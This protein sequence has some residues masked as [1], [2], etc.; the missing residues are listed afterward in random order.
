VRGRLSVLSRRDLGMLATPL[1]VIAAGIGG[2]ALGHR[3][4]PNVADAA[5]ARKQAQSAS[6]RASQLLAYRRARALAEPRGR[7]Q[8]TRAGR[9]AGRVAGKRRARLEN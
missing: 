1:V 9:K 7:D 4:A 6:A 8:G 3:A 5:Q 2:Y